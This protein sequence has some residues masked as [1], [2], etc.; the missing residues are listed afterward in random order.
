MPAKEKTAVVFSAGG[1][2]GA[3]QV[4]VW[5]ALAPHFR[6][7]IVVGTSIGAVNG[8]AVAGEC[9][10]ERLEEQWL[11]LD[12]LGRVQWQLPWGL[13]GVVN[14][15][16]IEQMIQE[17]HRAYP[18]RIDFGVVVTDTLRLR[19]VLVRSPEVTWQHLAGSVGMIGIYRQ[20]R[21]GRRV[22][23]DGGLLHA[24]P[25]WAAV[26][27]GATRVL[28]VNCLAKMPSA[29]VRGVV[30][31]FRR[32]SPWR[33]P[34]LPAEVELVTIKPSEDLGSAK[35]AMIWSRDNAERWIALGEKDG[36]ALC[37]TVEGWA[38]RLK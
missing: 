35:S 3:W 24:L 8:Y 37:R 1:M 38:A 11:A 23:S 33:I 4:G 6:P 9:P 32:V 27:M 19:P 22:F 2:Y 20:Y 30:K 25:V 14:S 26:E 5:K 7:D 18:P 10:I 21:I 36:A 29:V 12:A 15:T 31:S 13:R 28:A 16:A 34:E 17:L